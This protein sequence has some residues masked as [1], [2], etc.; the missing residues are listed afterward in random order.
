M[1]WISVKDRLPEDGCFA[2]VIC[3]RSFPKNYPARIG[4]FYDDVNLFY[5][6]SCDDSIEDAT[7]WMPLP[8]P[9]KT[10]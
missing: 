3:P 9:P 10:K 7:H 6:E 8:D 5:C 2:V 1:E 4:R